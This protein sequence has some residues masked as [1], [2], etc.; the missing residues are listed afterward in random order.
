MHHIHSLFGSAE[1]RL[2]AQ[3]YGPEYA[4]APEELP[5]TPEDYADD[6]FDRSIQHVQSLLPDLQRAGIP[7]QA[8]Y[9]SIAPYGWEMY[10]D[11][12]RPSRPYIRPSNHVRS[13]VH[14]SPYRR[15]PWMY[16]PRNWSQHSRFVSGLGIADVPYGVPPAFAAQTYGLI[17]LPLPNTPYRLSDMPGPNVRSLRWSSPLNRDRRSSL[18]WQSAVTPFTPAV[19][20]FSGPRPSPEGLTATADVEFTY[21]GPP[22]AITVFVDGTPLSLPNLPLNGQTILDPR[23]FRVSRQGN[24][25]QIW[26]DRR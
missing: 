18:T 14:Q 4:P 22:Q 20:P 13:Y 5:Q 12:P 2:L 16:T 17:R 1:R 24:R 26:Y 7:R 19:S 23:G 15:L 25:Y 10:P 6:R 8:F 9:P 3:R 21:A 11:G